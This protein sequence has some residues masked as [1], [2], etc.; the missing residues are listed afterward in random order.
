LKLRLVILACVP[1]LGTG[2]AQLQLIRDDVARVDRKVDSA[3]AETR[4]LQKDRSRDSSAQEL[5]VLR[6]DLTLQLKQLSA[7]IQ[8]IQ[9]R[10]GGIDQRLS[11]IDQEIGILRGTRKP[12]GGTDSSKS[13]SMSILE[14]TIKTASDDFQRGRY[15][16]AYR[17]FQD[18]LS[19]DSSGVLSARAVYQMGE[20]RYAQGNWD[21]AR[22]LFQRVVR[23]WPTADQ[24]VCASWF[25]MGLASE[26]LRQI[27]DRDSAWAK[28][29]NRCPGTNEAQRARDLLNR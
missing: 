13:Q 27:P 12:G 22:L 28:L 23:D 2:C 4:A 26:K 10:M 29:Q 24:Q 3:R 8:K 7:D 16:L 15:D 25:K 1:L 5:A 18:V 6:A 14:Q 9:S 21:E 19:R 17:G 20:C 11:R